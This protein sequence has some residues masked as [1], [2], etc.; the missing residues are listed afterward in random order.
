MISVQV[1][2]TQE[3]FASLTDIQASAPKNIWIVIDFTNKFCV[4]HVFLKFFYEVIMKRSLVPSLNSNL[5][6]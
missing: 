3:L 4:N 5:S 1:A 2:A 6:K